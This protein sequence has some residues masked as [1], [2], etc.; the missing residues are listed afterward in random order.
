MI[1]TLKNKTKSELQRSPTFKQL[2]LKTGF[3]K[4]GFGLVKWVLLL[5]EQME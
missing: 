4:Q 3:I 1:E 5:Q 2:C